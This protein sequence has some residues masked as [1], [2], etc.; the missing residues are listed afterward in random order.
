MRYTTVE[1]VVDAC[2]WTLGVSF[3]RGADADGLAP[4]V[5]FVCASYNEQSLR[6]QVK[7]AGVAGTNSAGAWELRFEHVARLGLKHRILF[8]TDTQ[9]EAGTLKIKHSS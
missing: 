3:P 8:L 6:E 1:L 2:P 4:E 9:S 5:V 7:A